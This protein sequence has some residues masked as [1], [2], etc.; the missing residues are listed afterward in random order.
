[1]NGSYCV[2]ENLADNGG[3]REAFRAYQK[4]VQEEELVAT[5]NYTLEQL[6][7]IGYGT[8]SW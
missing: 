1:V 4:V 6:F 8:V 2:N 5:G 7:F 3:V